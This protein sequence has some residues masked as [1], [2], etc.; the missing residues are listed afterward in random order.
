METLL[1][2]LVIILTAMIGAMF[3]VV[4]KKLGG[5]QDG[6]SLLML[7]QQ[8]GQMTQTLDAKLAEV[9]K[10]S[11]DQFGRTTGIMQ[12]VTEQAQ[13]MLSA[14]HSQSQNAIAAVTEKLTKLDETN[15]QV[16]NFAEQ[17][18]SLEDILKNPKHR[19]ILGE[20]QLEMVLKNVL[21]PAAYKLQYE[22][23][24]GEIVDA[25][26]FVKDKIIPVDSKFSLENYN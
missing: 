10:A 16:V 20:Y 4:Q 24:D 23:A 26:I 25:A 12:G 6:Q 11:Q 15:K 13:K 5:K 2:I 18:Q 17:L 8:M 19:G 22:F 3:F 21:P 14:I 7:Q 9:H 1:I